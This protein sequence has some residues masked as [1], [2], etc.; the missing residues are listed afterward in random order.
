MLEIEEGQNILPGLLVPVPE[1]ALPTGN[2]FL[3][4]HIFWSTALCSL[5]YFYYIRARMH[6]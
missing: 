1:E 4:T 6:Y 2:S 5:S 3:G